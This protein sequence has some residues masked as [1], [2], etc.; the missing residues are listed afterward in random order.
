MTLRLPRAGL[1]VP[2]M[3]ASLLATPCGARA[4]AKA[5]APE[6]ATAALVRRA[7]MS[8]ARGVKDATVTVYEVADFECPFCA[9]F[10]NQTFPRIDS[11]YVKPGKVQWVFVNLP[12]VIHANAFQAAEAALC[13]GAVGDRFWAMHEK[14]YASQAEWKDAADP[15]A[16]FL[17]YARELSVPASAYGACIRADRVWSVIM[18]D[19]MY[20]A[21]AQIDGT[22]TY[23]IG[24]QVAAVGSKSFDEW[25]AILDKAIQDAASR[26]KP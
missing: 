18:R 17:R 1:L 16:V 15:Q 9:Q 14:L 20:A 5:A 13:A 24:N 7:G 19:A 11:A 22:P 3:A 10:A 21:S 23:I 2:I 25:K 26:K 12:L 8:R 6:E 4:Q